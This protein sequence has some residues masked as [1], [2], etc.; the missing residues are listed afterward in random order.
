MRKPIPS[1]VRPE[2]VNPDTV[3]L[4]K[5]YAD[6]D[7]LVIGAQSGSQR[8]LDV[9]HRGHDVESIYK[10]VDA[11][12]L[13]GLKVNVDFIFG[14][15]GETDENMSST[16]KV[17]KDLHQSGAKIHAHTFIPLPQTP[18]KDENTVRTSSALR[19]EINRLCANG[20][21]YGLWRKQ[22]KMASMIAMKL[23]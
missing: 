11:T 3:K 20:M 12:L 5:K 18:L 13:A 15:P 6:N 8:L 4:V 2:H 22:E 16:L 23:H 9:V 21:I 14:L 19:K 17:I 10:A 1:E 7:N